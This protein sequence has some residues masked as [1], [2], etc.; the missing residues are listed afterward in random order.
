MTERRIIVA[1]DVSRATELRQLVRQIKDSNCRVK[2]G[3]E[4]FTSIGPLAIEIC[5]DA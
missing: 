5:H 1:L 4:L 3:K 2:I